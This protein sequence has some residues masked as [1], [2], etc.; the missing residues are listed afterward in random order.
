MK[1]LPGRR[2]KNFREAAEQ[3]LRRFYRRFGGL[4]GVLEQ[5]AKW[6]QVYPLRCKNTVYIVAKAFDP[7]AGCARV[8]T[9]KPVSRCPYCGQNALDYDVE[10]YK[11]LGTTVGL[12]IKINLGE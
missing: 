3:E 10:V 1:I 9:D 12:P 5:L 4:R 8:W 7:S 6:N 2:V 11:A